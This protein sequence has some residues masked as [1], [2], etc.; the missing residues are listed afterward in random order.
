MFPGASAP[1]RIK[2]TDEDPNKRYRGTDGLIRLLIDTAGAGVE[3]LTFDDLI[4][5]TGLTKKNLTR[6]LGKARV[7]T[8]LELYGWALQS[9]RTRGIKS[10]LVRIRLAA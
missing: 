3:V 8:I 1:V 6:T 2:R 9:S 7:R 4:K 5:H 10:R